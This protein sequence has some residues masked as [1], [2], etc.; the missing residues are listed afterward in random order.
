MYDV[1]IAVS[2]Y[3]NKQLGIFRPFKMTSVSDI[4]LERGYYFEFCSCDRKELLNVW[5]RCRGCCCGSDSSYLQSQN[6]ETCWF[7]KT[8]HFKTFFCKTKS[9]QCTFC[10]TVPKIQVVIFLWQINWKAW[11]QIWLHGLQRIALQSPQFHDQPTNRN[12]CFLPYFIVLQ[13][14]IRRPLC[15]S[16]NDE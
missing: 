2:Q 11:I 14:W 9:K 10:W 15:Q 13:T 12:D 1:Q 16:V 5:V 4:G 8:K 6:L 7:G 3:E